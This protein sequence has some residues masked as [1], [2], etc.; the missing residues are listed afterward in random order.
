VS[1]E[2]IVT[3]MLIE[4]AKLLVEP[5]PIK[6]YEARM[7]SYITKRKRQIAAILVEHTK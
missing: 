1:L 2:D 6:T 7:D 5:K 4:E 3:L